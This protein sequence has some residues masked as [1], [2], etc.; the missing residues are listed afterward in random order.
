ML[1]CSNYYQIQVFIITFTPGTTVVTPDDDD[2]DGDTNVGLIVG[3]TLGVFAV[4]IIVAL[5]VV[6]WW[7]KRNRGSHLVGYS[8]DV[9]QLKETK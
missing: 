1:L 6:W 4:C 9:M 2:D 7:M 8:A 3:A 5:V